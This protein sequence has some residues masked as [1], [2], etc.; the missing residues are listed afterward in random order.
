MGEIDCY[1]D[2]LAGA[3]VGPRR[4]KA[5]LVTEA[6]HGLIDAASAHHADGMAWPEAERLAVAEFGAVKELLPGYQAELGIAQMRRTAMLVFTVLV[7]QAVVWSRII[8]PPV[9]RSGLPATLDA[10][11]GWLGLLAMLGA[12]AAVISLR[13]L[14]TRRDATVIAGFSALTLSILI[15]L[16]GVAITATSGGDLRW[17][18]A[19]GLLPM[20][21]TAHSARRCLRA[22]R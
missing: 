20:A 14:P 19:F 9:P 1:V 8:D 6:R 4:A 16:L 13:Y 3:L 10:M 18:I 11:I 21:W 2:R 17:T 12:A 22:S 5:D 15:A 7:A